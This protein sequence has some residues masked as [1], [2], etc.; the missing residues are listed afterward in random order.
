MRCRFADCAHGSEPGCRVREALEAGALEDDR[1][2]SFLKLQRELRYQT[3]AEDPLARRAQKQRW[4]ATQKSL[5]NHPKY[6]R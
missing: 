6:R 5:K 4:K 2:E 3:I 1:W